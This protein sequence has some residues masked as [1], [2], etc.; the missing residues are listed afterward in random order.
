MVCYL[1]KKNTMLCFQL[2]G[3]ARTYT[4]IQEHSVVD[5]KQKT[6]ELQSTNVSV[7]I[8]LLPHGLLCC[9]PFLED[10]DQLNV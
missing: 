8:M 7:L 1:N 5:P 9:E 4:Y 2:I 10:T 3:N 6:F